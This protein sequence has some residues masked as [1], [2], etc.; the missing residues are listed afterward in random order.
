M[1]YKFFLH[2]QCANINVRVYYNTLQGR[3]LQL[4]DL[5]FGL[6]GQN[7][8][9]KLEHIPRVHCAPEVACSSLTMYTAMLCRL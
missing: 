2:L 7:A 3:S 4:L 1:N 9:I 6:T 5:Q 8:N